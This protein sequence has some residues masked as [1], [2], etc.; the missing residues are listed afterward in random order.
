MIWIFRDNSKSEIFMQKKFL[1]STKNSRR[2]GFIIY[3]FVD[4]LCDNIILKEKCISPY[5]RQ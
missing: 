4:L 5:Y 2:D 1:I 3:H